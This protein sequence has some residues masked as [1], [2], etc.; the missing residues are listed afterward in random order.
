MKQN[1][2]Q[3]NLTYQ[4]FKV[5]Q[6]AQI[7]HN[8]YAFHCNVYYP[9]CF[10]LFFPGLVSSW[11]FLDLWLIYGSNISTYIAMPFVHVT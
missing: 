4:Q 10:L 5:A 2:I 3:F 9:S 6:V 7:A 11:S 1:K 8:F